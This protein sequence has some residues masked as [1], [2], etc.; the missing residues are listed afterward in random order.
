MVRPRMNCHYAVVQCI[1]VMYELD[2][3][4]GNPEKFDNGDSRG[5]SLALCV[6][7]VKFPFM[8]VFQ[9]SFSNLKKVLLK[10]N[11]LEY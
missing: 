2:R 9:W 10:N 4:F 6:L 3:G 1:G 7:G 5:G 8:C 11:S